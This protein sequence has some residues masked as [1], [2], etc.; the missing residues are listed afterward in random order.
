MSN[1]YLD[2]L[3]PQYKSQRQ[4]QYAV[5]SGCYAGDSLRNSQ[6]AEEFAQPH[7]YGNGDDEIMHIVFLAS[8]G[9]RSGNMGNPRI[10]VVG[11]VFFFNYSGEPSFSNAAS[12]NRMCDMFGSLLRTYQPLNKTRFYELITQFKNHTFA[13]GSPLS[14]YS[15]PDQI[16]D[17]YVLGSGSVFPDEISHTGELLRNPSGLYMVTIRPGQALMMTDLLAGN[18]NVINVYEYYKRSGI[19]FVARSVDSRGR[20]SMEMVDDSYKYR[21]PATGA[22]RPF[23][24]SDV[25]NLIKERIRTEFVIS[26]SLSLTG[27]A[28]EQAVSDYMKRHLVLVSTTCRCFE[29]ESYC[30]TE[31]TQRPESSIFPLAPTA[32]QWGNVHPGPAGPPVSPGGGAM[33]RRE[34]K[35]SV[36]NRNKN[37][38]KCK[39]KKKNRKRTSKPHQ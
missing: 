14:I 20:L 7:P 1:Y 8:H 15:P 25:F 6:T 2:K 18:P 27:D 11:N 35:K 24:L 31:S 16:D 17:I 36:K 29:D 19:P 30:R 22:V 4:P 26:Q 21:D 23:M 10:P 3:G 33:S 28:L 32:S 39:N 34:H 37:R 12:P 5:P 9:A 13:P 38:N